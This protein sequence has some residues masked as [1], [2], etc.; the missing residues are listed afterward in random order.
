MVEELY[1][2]EVKEKQKPE[3]ERSVRQKKEK[4]RIPTCAIPRQEDSGCFLASQMQL[5]PS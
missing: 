2:S 3:K 4:E 1:S 5:A